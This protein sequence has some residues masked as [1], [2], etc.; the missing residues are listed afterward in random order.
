MPIEKYS[1]HE[2]AEYFVRHLND[3]LSKT[4]TSC[5]LRPIAIAA[6]RET[7]FQIAFEEE[8]APARQIELRTRFGPM[9][10]YLGQDCRT[11]SGIR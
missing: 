11:S 3:V 6:K 5:P 1:P 7:Y 10:L 9:F 4:I 8:E 2:A